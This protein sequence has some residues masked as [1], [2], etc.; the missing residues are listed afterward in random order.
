MSRIEHSSHESGIIL[1]AALWTIIL[2]SMIAGAMVVLGRNDVEISSLM[3]ERA[4]AQAM[5]DAGIAWGIAKLLDHGSGDPWAIDGWPRSVVLRN[6]PIIVSIRD[7]L[8]RVDL[9]AAPRETLIKIFRASLKDESLAERLVDSIEDWRDQDHV[10]RVNGAEE[11]D[12][13]AAGRSYGPRNGL[14]ESVKEVS[15]VLGMTDD[16]YHRVKQLLTVWS[17]KPAVDLLTAD[18]KIVDTLAIGNSPDVPVAGNANNTA[19]IIDLTGRAFTVT[20]WVELRHHVVSEKAVSVRF[21]RNASEPYWILAT[22]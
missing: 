19:G 22:E 13:R 10:K 14:F 16:A 7:E 12:Y 5:S 21:T 3:A 11:E 15:Q 18:K 8:G 1:V 17:G 20:A 9:N 2:L 4:K 6:V